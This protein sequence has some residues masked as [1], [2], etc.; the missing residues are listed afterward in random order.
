MRK[1]ITLFACFLSLLATGGP[2]SAQQLQVIGDS[3]AGPICAGPLGPGP[4]AA[5]QQYLLQHQQQ[6]AAAPQQLQVINVV[7]GVGPICNGPLGPA[8]CNLVQQ[9]LLDHSSVAGPQTQTPASPG[10]NALDPQHLAIECAKRAG[11]DVSTFANCAEQQVILP[12]NQQALLDCA[13]SSS[14]SQNFA[15][16]AAPQLGIR[17]SKEQ[18]VVAQCAMK[19]DGDSSDFL[20]CAGSAIIGQNLTPDQQAVLDCASD[21]NGDASNFATCSASQLLGA[22]A[23]KEQRIALECAAQSEGDYAVMASCAGANLFNMNLNPEQQIAVQCVVQAAANRMR[24]R[25]AW[26]PA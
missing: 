20:S 4:C 14:T 6:Q 17:L 25:V 8:P 22:H 13:V 23:S 12:Q 16:C 21:S 2:S 10:G 11:F 18:Q 5:I 26:R 15:E 24:P 3:P 1:A 19:S 9:Y 7:P